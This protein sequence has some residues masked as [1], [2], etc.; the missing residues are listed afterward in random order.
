MLNIRTSQ[1][2]DGIIFTRHKVTEIVKSH[3]RCIGIKAT[4]Q[5][6]VKF[7]KSAATSSSMRPELG[8][9]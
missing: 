3:G 5:A 2:R 6:P 8:L 1:R 7:E 4:D 9:I